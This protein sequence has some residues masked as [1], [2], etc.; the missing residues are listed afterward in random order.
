MADGAV[1][2]IDRVITR[3][4]CARTF[5][6]KYLAEYAPG[7]RTRGMTLRDILVSPPIWFDDQSNTVTITWSLSSAQAW[8]EMTWKGRPDPNLALWWDGIGEL[9]FERTR[10]VAAAAGDLEHL[11]DV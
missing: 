3:P 11:C 8:W 1:F 2:V 4:G 10:S 5:V 7:A 9:V 6:D